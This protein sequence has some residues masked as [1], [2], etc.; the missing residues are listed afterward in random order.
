MK[1][2]L[3]IHCRNYEREGKNMSLID[4]WDWEVR[5]L[6]SFLSA[7]VHAGEEWKRSIPSMVVDIT[8]IGI[9]NK[10]KIGLNFNLHSDEVSSRIQIP[11]FL[12]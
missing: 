8:L 12:L 3:L 2:W 1:A 5:K 4:I 9:D 10:T 6:T 7:S 11:N